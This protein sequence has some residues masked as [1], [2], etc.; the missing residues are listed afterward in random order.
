M[1]AEK[2]ANT[3]KSVKHEKIDRQTIEKY[4]GY[5]FD[6][7][8]I[9]E[10]RRYDLKGRNERGA[11][12]K[13]YFTDTGLRN[14]RLDFAFPDEGQIFENIIY[15][16]LIY[17]GY[18]VS[19]GTFDSIEKDPEGKSVRK[20]NEIDFFARKGIHQYYI[21]VSLDMADPKTRARELR[22]FFKL[23]DQVR[24]IIVMNKPVK[25]SLDEN[26]FTIIGMEDFLL[27]LLQRNYTRIRKSLTNG[28]RKNIFRVY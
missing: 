7:F 28:F 21:Q 5:F 2:I 27:S 20:T 9:R 23:N 1:N 22:P 24:K 12:R 3:Y 14:A 10:A 26:D 16:E 4:L 6:A 11:L 8:L 25:E 18:S 13:Y 15:N 19:V 17:Q